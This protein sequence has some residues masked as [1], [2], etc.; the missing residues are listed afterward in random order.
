MLSASA[1]LSPAQPEIDASNAHTVCLFDP[2]DRLSD[3]LHLP[4]VPS[5]H[6][7]IVLGG[8]E[9]NACPLM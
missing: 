4:A 5:R 6:F 1:F 9:D 3:C 7:P 2:E 8:E